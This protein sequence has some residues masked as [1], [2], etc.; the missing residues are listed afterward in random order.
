LVPRALD[1]VGVGSGVGIDEVDAV[2]HGLMRV[3]LSIEIAVRTPAVTN[4]RSAG[5]CYVPTFIATYHLP[6]LPL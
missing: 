4:D 3:T 2:V 5:F 6:Y 1:G